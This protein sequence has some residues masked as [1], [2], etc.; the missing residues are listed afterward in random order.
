MVTEGGVGT[1]SSSIETVVV[2]ENVGSVD[3]SGL[4]RMVGLRVE[5]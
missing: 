1:K 3:A 4:D 5:H 2:W